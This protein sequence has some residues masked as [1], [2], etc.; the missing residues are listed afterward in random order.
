M[1]IIDTFYDLNNEY[2]SR[3][4][5]EFYLGRVSAVNYNSFELQVENMDL[6]K[7]RFNQDDILLPGTINYLVLIDS[8]QGVFLGE[9]Y[10][11][12]IFKENTIHN[13]I[14][15]EQNYD[16]FPQLSI[17]IIGIYSNDKKIFVLS[18]LKNVSIT[19]KVYV[20]SQKAVNRYAQSLERKIK[21]KVLKNI[22]Q[23]KLNNATTNNFSIHV[24]NLFDHHLMVVGATNSGKSTSSL[25][26]LDKIKMA[27]GRI[28]IIDPTGEYRDSF[29]DED[30][31]V[32]KCYL[33]KDTYIHTGI[34][35]NNQWRMIFHPNQN[36]QEGVLFE[37][38][39]L[40]KYAKY[41]SSSNKT[42]N[43]V[44]NSP[45]ILN[46]MFENKD[47][48]DEDIDIQLLESQINK[49]SVSLNSRTH[50]YEWS[51]FSLSNNEWL[52]RKIQNVLSF[53]NISKF[54]QSN[55]DDSL[56][57][58]NKIKEFVEKGDKKVLYI[59]FSELGFEE[60]FGK[61]VVDIVCD[62]L[63]ACEK[64]EPFVFF[65]DEV[66]RYA[67]E[68]DDNGEVISKLINISREGRKKGIFL[69]LTTQSPQD[70][71]EIMLNQIGTLIIHRLT[72]YRDINA[73]KG[74]IS[75]DEISSLYN[76]DVGE[77]LISSINLIQDVF[78]KFNKSSRIHNNSTPKL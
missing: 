60:I 37:S 19:D 3:D 13:T 32:I 24:D 43:L 78:V 61:L 54:L 52:V 74:F 10:K 2:Q 67:F 17:K 36:T 70:I 26:I 9:V 22:A 1:S 35:S 46:K 41:K 55:Q 47:I 44:G 76:L 45:D 58:I 53:T 71:P 50:L 65:I 27:N 66:H 42:I 72:G 7:Y 18:G 64:I 14:M 28:L 31:D 49:S 38:I 68:K 77:A 48:N 34:L 21:G 16:I 20:A 25:T 75:S 40:L 62:A 59:D 5:S 6:I 63:L 39:R 4:K 33:G 8:A 73:I 12:E 15:R 30:N 23:V 56:D 69:F 51:S 57:L 11:S 29:D